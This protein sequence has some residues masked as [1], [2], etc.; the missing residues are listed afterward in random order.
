MAVEG[1][2]KDFAITEELVVE[3]QSLLPP[4][5]PATASEDAADKTTAHHKTS[6][7]KSPQ[8]TS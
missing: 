4:E 5:A 1:S 6:R 3:M 7:K 2:F 8:A